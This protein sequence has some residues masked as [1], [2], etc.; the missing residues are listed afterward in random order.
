MTK[1][2]TRRTVKIA[3]DESAE[4]VAASI[5]RGAMSATLPFLAACQTGFLI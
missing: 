1:M 5:R 3:A 4:I 2:T